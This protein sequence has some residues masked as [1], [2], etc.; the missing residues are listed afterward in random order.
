MNIS[1]AT[2][3]LI[4]G[5]ATST[6]E[7]IS[8]LDQFEQ[9]SVAV[10]AFL[11]TKGGT[12]IAGLDQSE[13]KQTY[14]KVAE[15]LRAYLYEQVSPNCVMS[16]TV[17]DTSQGA[18]LVIDVP[19][20][21][22]TPYT[23]EGR[24]FLRVGKGNEI[25]DS[26][27]IRTMV[28]EKGTDVQRW[29]RRPSPTLTVEDFDLNLI[30]K[31]VQLA[32]ERRGLRFENPENTISVLEQ[33]ELSAFGQFTNA[34]DVVFGRNVAQRLPQ[35]RVRAV[36]YL[37]DRGNE[38]IDDQLFE[39]SALQLVENILAFI[40]RH[41]P[42]ARQFDPEE[43]QRQDVPHF[44]FESVNEG[45]VNA[46]V[47]RDYSSFTGSVKI[48][49]YP[50]RLEIW[51]SGKLPKG[52]TARKLETAKH[53]SILVNPDISH[54]FYLNGLMER[55]GRGTYKIVRECRS[56]GMRTPEWKNINLGVRLTFFAGLHDLQLDL[57]ERQI[58]LIE[59]ARFGDKIVTTDYSKSFAQDV[60]A[61]QARRDLEKLEDFGF[62]ERAGSGR[63][64]VFYRT[65]KK[66]KR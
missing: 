10:C 25:A 63:G 40:R 1:L 47:H 6:V 30:S 56:L 55:V 2:Q 64:T 14:E 23:Y 36:R 49:I 58:G 32:Q 46:L 54:L 60:T 8:G 15:E 12:I 13:Q 43:A 33:L 4:E 52:L 38:F 29:E 50:D 17:D 59:Q 20:G 51:N 66:L 61:R 18:V 62:L 19:N 31:T 42:V 11:N 53:E 37:E 34:A 48:G 26:Q 5:G 35:I 41:V 39:G 3:R 24:V 28:L 44:P 27:A 45:I 16:V 7:L 9:I 65:E 57:N 22:D 21:R